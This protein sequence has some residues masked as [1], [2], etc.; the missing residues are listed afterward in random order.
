LFCCLLYG[1]SSPGER[2]VGPA[3]KKFFDLEAYFQSEIERLNESDL[4]FK[5][6]VTLNGSME[7]RQVATVNFGEELKLFLDADI[8]QV[9]LLDKYQSDSIAGGA[10]LQQLTHTALDSSLLVRKIIVHYDQGEV[11]RLD[12]Y[13][14]QKSFVGSS[15]QHLHYEPGKG[16]AITSLQKT[17]LTNAQE[18]KIETFFD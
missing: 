11:D 4:H 17:L 13:K 6:E 1:C 10:G 5:K 14:K 18:L 16:Y 9:A 2:T 7:T 15:Q 8:N 3:E 12:V